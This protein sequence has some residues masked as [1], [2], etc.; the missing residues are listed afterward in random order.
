[1]G[2]NGNA[3]A[4]LRRTLVWIDTPDDFVGWVPFALAAGHVIAG[5]HRIAAI[6]ASG[7]PFSVVWAGALLSRWTGLPL[8]ADFRDTWILDPQDPFGTIGGSFRAGASVARRRTLR[9]LEGWCLAVA[10]AV[11]FTS[12]ATRSLYKMHYPDLEERFHLILNGV[13]LEDFSCAPTP[14][15]SRP[16]IAH[17]GTLH[18][19]QRE[20]VLRLFEAVALASSEIPDLHVIFVGPIGA[21]LRDDLLGAA[22]HLGVESRL[23]LA[24]PVSHLEAVGWLRAA[25]LLL[26]FAGDNPFIRLSKISE[27]AAAERPMIAFA[28]PGS[29]T[30]RDVRSHGGDVLHEAPPEHVAS[31]LIEGVRR[32][33]ASRD[34]AT[35]FPF[36]H[37]HPLNR[38][39]EAQQ[40]AEILDAVRQR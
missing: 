21:V 29:Q 28:G 32:G 24:G 1:V 40:L 31:K 27:Y 2:A 25:D 10:R 33:V 18:D 16:T 9:R 8:V 19:Y 34:Q 20:Q 30:A 4:A 26:L 17:V 13:D 39:T 23:G 5:R 12:E 7:P 6:H 3:T 15:P 38:R 11:L 36:P 37:P 35:E 22:R 14:R